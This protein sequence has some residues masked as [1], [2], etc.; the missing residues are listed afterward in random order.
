MAAL[1]VRPPVWPP[2]PTNVA[3]GRADARLSAQKAFFEAALAG[4]TAASAPA[5]DAPRASPAQAVRAAIQVEA[6]TAADKLPRPGSLL[7]IWV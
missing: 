1:P 3:P 2:A 4:K 6:A 7:D 5:A